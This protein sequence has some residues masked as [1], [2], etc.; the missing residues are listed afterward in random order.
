MRTSSVCRW[1]RNRAQRLARLA[2]VTALCWNI[3]LS[4]R[5][6]DHSSQDVASAVERRLEELEGAVTQLQKQPPHAPQPA[7]SRL[8]GTY[9]NGFVFSTDDGQFRLIVRGYLQSDARLFI[10]NKTATNDQFLFRRVRPVLEGTVFRHFDFK[11]MPD[12]AGSKST[13]FDAYVDAHYVPA[14]Q[15]QVGKLKPPLGLE[16]LQSARHLFFAERGLTNDLVPARDIGAQLH[17]D[18]WGAALSYAAGIFNGVPDL[19]TADT[20][21]DS[22]KDFEGR[23]FAQPWKNSTVTA[24]KGLGLGVAGSY[25]HERGS[26]AN[27]NLP[28][29]ASAG[30]ATFFSYTLSASA[31][32]ETVVALGAHSRISPQGYYFWGPLGLLGD[33][34]TS[35]QAVGGGG[36]SATLRHEAWQLLGSYVLTGEAM[37]FEG[38]NPAHPFDPW[39][40]T[41]GALQ[42]CARYGTLDVDEA[43]FRDGF[44]DATRS[45]HEAREWALGANWYLNRN[46]KFVLNYANTDFKGGAVGGNRRTEK[47]VLSRIQTAF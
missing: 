22:D 47:A 43:A 4:A 6:A 46:I 8:S 23:A 21:A 5:A 9:Q 38:V 10:D 16:R 33:Y 3:P 15:L 34:V 39:A 17:G 40:G 29:Y 36:K 12:F 20:D 7:A 11:L 24:L 32:T 1:R 14:L 2:L 44:A 45:A 19:S 13:L 35:A 27:T 41:W 25:G 42:I 30:Q 26:A 18:L 28:S 31:P 37:S